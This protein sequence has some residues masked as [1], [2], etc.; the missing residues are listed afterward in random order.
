MHPKIPVISLTVLK[1]MKKICNEKQKAIIE[2]E[3]V[4]EYIMQKNKNLAQKE[5]AE[6]G[7]L[8]EYLS[9][10]GMVSSWS[11]SMPIFLH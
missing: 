7:T 11:T 8:L 5:E 9:A 4:V 1:E 6:S 10:M 3:S 2:T